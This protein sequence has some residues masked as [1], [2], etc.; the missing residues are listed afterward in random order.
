MK[1]KNIIL[2]ALLV[3]FTG[4]TVVSANRVFP[5]LDWYWSKDAKEQRRGEKA[6]QQPQALP[7]GHTEFVPAT[8]DTTKKVMAMRMSS[9]KPPMPP[10]VESIVG[11]SEPHTV[12]HRPLP[13]PSVPDPRHTKEEKRLQ[14]MHEAKRCA[15]GGVLYAYEVQ[16]NNHFFDAPDNWTAWM[17]QHRGPQQEAWTQ[18]GQS[19]TE[20]TRGCTVAGQEGFQ[21]RL[22]RTAP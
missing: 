2:L 17:I 15:A 7:G 9:V 13:H 8:P 20:P 22:V 19:T 18:C 14:A 1:K 4:C 21:Y 3:S 12:P 5:K 16:D 11:A 10:M 6:A